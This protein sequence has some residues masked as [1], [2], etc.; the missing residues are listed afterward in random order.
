LGPEGYTPTAGIDLLKTLTE[1]ELA[2]N[3]GK[4]SKLVPHYFGGLFW[5]GDMDDQASGSMLSPVEAGGTAQLCE[6]VHQ[7]ASMF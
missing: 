6:R 3:D 5:T 2:R 1:T 4:A 7:P